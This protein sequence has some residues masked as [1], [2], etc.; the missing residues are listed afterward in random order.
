MQGYAHEGGSQMSEA[1]ERDVIRKCVELATK[2]TGKKP[3]GWRA[4][5]YQIREH[6]VRVLEEEG[7][8]YGVSSF[9]PFSR[10]SLARAGFKG[11]ADDETKTD[12]SLTHHDS[13]PY[14][15]PH[16]P[17]ITP[18]DFSPSNPASSWMV[19]LPTPAAPTATTLVELPCNWYMEDM[20]PLQFLPS[21]PNSHGYVPATGILA[22]WQERFRFL[23]S[24]MADGVGGGEGFLFPLVLHPDTSGMAHVIGMID[25]MI[26]WLKAQGAPGEVEFVTYEDAAREWRGGQKI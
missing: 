10:F 11:L 14:F 1:Q 2:L 6:T 9:P 22:M 23:Y 17:A 19:P 20:T 21:A 24:E 18:I 7:F 3:R 16:A 8:V 15:L 12:T 25:T 4:P 26:G 13:Q 5:L